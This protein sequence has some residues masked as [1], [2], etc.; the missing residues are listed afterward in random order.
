MVAPIPRT[1]VDN[2]ADRVAELCPP[3]KKLS[4]MM[5]EYL[6]TN[7]QKAFK[8]TDRDALAKAHV[9]FGLFLMHIGEHTDAIDN[10]NRG[11][12]MQGEFYYLNLK[13]AAT[14]FQWYGFFNESTE[15][16]AELF[17]ADL[18]E[19][20]PSALFSYIG[21]VLLQGDIQR[22]R[23]ILQKHSH[24]LAMIDRGLP[25][26]EE[27]IESAKVVFDKVGLTQADIAWS[28]SQALSVMREFKAPFFELDTLNPFI[29]DE[30]QA[31]VH[32]EVLADFETTVAMEKALFEK[33]YADNKVEIANKLTYLFLARS[34]DDIQEEVENAS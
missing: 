1:I 27:F 18:K 20:Y 14:I 12:G 25:F 9:W 26:I 29:V 11:L 22:A 30:T 31:A 7:F 33:V 24:Q 5:E 2:L 34:I 16:W 4:P 17:N 28:L 15:L 3:K 21:P 6:Y 32:I 19:I 23:E 13:N 8:A 10:I